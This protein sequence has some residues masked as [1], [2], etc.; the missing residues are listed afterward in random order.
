MTL[1]YPIKEETLTTETELRKR[2]RR[3]P[4]VARADA[5]SILASGVYYIKQ[6]GIEVRQFNSRHGL[7]IVLP[8]LLVDATT[9]QYTFA[10]KP[11]DLPA[12]DDEP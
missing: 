1:E 3:R 4:E 6:A 11:P 5:P 2:A 12:R 7:V 9:G 8:E 10:S